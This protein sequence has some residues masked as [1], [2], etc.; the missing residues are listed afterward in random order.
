M[1]QFWEN[2][3]IVEPNAANRTGAKWPGQEIK[4]QR[5]SKNDPWA[6][7]EEVTPA[8]VKLELKP[9]I[10]VPDYD[11]QAANARANDA[12][13]RAAGADERARAEWEATHNPDGSPKP[14]APVGYRFTAD[15]SLEPIPGGPAGSASKA[16]EAQQKAAQFLGRMLLAEQQ[17]G[18]VPEGS[19]DARTAIGQWLHETVPG[20]ENSFN[21]ANRQLS[22]QAARNFVAAS[23]RQES[24]AAIGAQEYANQYRIFFPM[25][26]DGPEVIKQK[27]E[28]RRQAVQGF[29][30]AAGPLA[31]QVFAESQ[32]RAPTRDAAPVG[33]GGNG[34]GPDNG[35]TGGP[36]IRDPEM[37]GGLP[38]GTEIQ[39][40]ADQP[41]RAFSRERA[42]IEHQGIN[43]DQEAQMLAMY[44]QNRGNPGF[45]LDTAKQWFAAKGINAPT[46]ADLA[47][48][49]EWVRKGGQVGQIDTSGYEQAFNQELDARLA[50]QGFD[51]TSGGAYATRASRGLEWGLSDEIEGVG[52]A[53]GNLF[54][55]EGVADGYLYNRDLQR[56]AFERMEQEQGWLGTAA[57][58]GGG[59]VGGG[60]GAARGPISAARAAREGAIAGTIAGFGYGEGTGDSLT[61]AALGGVTG[62]AIGAGIG[63]AGQAIAARRAARG[64]SDSAQAYAQAQDY[65]I[66]LSIGDVGGRSAKMI[67]RN[68]DAQPAS[69]SI[70]NAPRQRLQGQI[71]SAVE[72]V[73]G[74]FGPETSFRGMGEAAQSGANRWVDKFNQVSNKA[75]DAIPIKAEQPAVLDGT[76]E[77]LSGLAGGFRSNSAMA[78]IMRNPRF[79]RY[80]DALTPNDTR[81]AGQV[82]YTAATDQ[83][84]GAEEALSRAR[85]EASAN[86]GFEQSQARD[87]VETARS[88]YDDLT[89][90]ARSQVQEAQRGYDAIRAQNVSSA[91]L[92]DARNQIQQAQAR[93]DALA[94]RNR[95]VPE[96]AQALRGLDEAEAAFTS[97]R[98]REP[99]SD[100]VSA[101]EA[102][103]TKARQAQ[104]AAYIEARQAPMGG[105]LSWNDLKAF[106]SAIGEEAGQALL[107]DGTS[108]TQLRTLYSGLSKDMEATAAQQGPKAL[109]A[110]KRANDLYASGQARID[111]AIKSLIGNNGDGQAEKAAAFL[112]KI[113]KDGRG[114]GDLKALSEVRKTLR[115]DEWAQV[116]NA[117]IRLLGQPANSAGRE[118]SPASFIRAYDD[119]APAAKNLLFGGENKEL[120]QNL[121]GFS[122]VIRRVAQ[123]DSTRNASGSAYGLAGAVTGG[124]GATTGAAIGA[125]FGGPVGAIFGVLLGKAGANTSVAGTAKLWT[126][127]RFVRWA[128]G[129]SKMLR[130]AERTGFD[131]AANTRQLSALARIAAN[132]NAIAQDLAGLSQALQAA[133][134]SP[135]RSAAAPAL[136]SGTSPA[137]QTRAQ[138]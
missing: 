102:E 92:V 69:A 98:F 61:G 72:N 76:R 45:T 67:E 80:L 121:D 49:V 75:Y 59:L 132:D 31:Q 54:S 34:T 25:P 138:Q 107:S 88:A 136:A 30:I 86:L 123:N 71:D 23:L 114:S 93:F 53:I 74:N 91:S 44:A 116:S 37:R 32:Q 38:V 111:G 36:G 77:A 10:S 5:N 7:F 83:V 1:A 20:L 12:N 95:D 128:T 13:T 48:T 57:E 46:D 84:R 108:K 66:D 51:P 124:A 55:N 90:Q 35:P 117:F 99:S 85:Q 118:F 11:K 15:G 17:Y 70:M 4:Q 56:R 42:L 81:Q 3:Q 2:D 9:L 133:L 19:R 43:L 122:D 63:K 52:G 104:D 105:N 18:Q 22:D 134:A 126:N 135:A 21:S 60:I 65:G 40:S 82:R 27:A 115:P 6:E 109:A 119:M 29:G 8:P 94:S 129:Y 79:A 14:Q 100:A 113:A 106:R 62:G 96:V 24:G 127:P 97:Q 101:A 120:R 28:A 16:T 103:L 39:W 78:G 26:G 68:L 131:E 58:L 110:F 50:A 112:Q 130:V 33:V 47:K 73:A 137:A 125:A 89:A 87:A 64:P 41:E